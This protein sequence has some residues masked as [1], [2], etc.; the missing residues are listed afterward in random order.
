MTAKKEKR[1]IDH[2]IN[3]AKIALDADG[4]IVQEMLPCRLW[5][6]LALCIK[7]V[8][9]YSRESFRTLSMEDR[10]ML[11]SNTSISQAHREMCKEIL[12]WS[13]NLRAQCRYHLMASGIK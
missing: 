9:S 7:W 11:A 1:T 6:A 3:M 8:P 5:A 13:D 12:G 2:Y 10:L 4:D